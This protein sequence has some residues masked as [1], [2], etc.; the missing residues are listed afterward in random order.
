MK[1]GT[2]VTYIGFSKREHGIVKSRSQSLDHVFFVVYK[3]GGDWDHYQD[4]TASATNAADLVQGWIG[5]EL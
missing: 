2:K 1:P 4:Y 3:C 5:E